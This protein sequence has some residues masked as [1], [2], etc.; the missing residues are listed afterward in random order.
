MHALTEQQVRRSFVNCSQ[1][2][3]KALT[4]PSVRGLVV[5]RALLYPPDDD[6]EAAGAPPQAKEAY[7]RALDHYQRA[8]EALRRART[9]EDVRAVAETAADGRYEM[10]VARAHLEHATWERDRGDPG[11]YQAHVLHRAAIGADAGAERRHDQLPHR[12]GLRRRR[13]RLSARQQVAVGMG[14]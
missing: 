14:R 11:Q 12:D 3:A 9:V 10:A 7:M 6:V 2:E 4:L 5:G 13:L 8:D 1:G